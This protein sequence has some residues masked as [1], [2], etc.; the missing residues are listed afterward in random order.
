MRYQF[1]AMA[2]ALFSSL[3][4]FAEVQEVDHNNFDQII[5]SGDTVVEFY[6]SSCPACKKFAPVYDAVSED[7]KSDLRFTKIE[8][9]REREVA[10]RYNIKH[11]PTLILFRDGKEKERHVG[12]LNT[13][14]LKSLID[15]TYN[16]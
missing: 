12:G 4:G 11:T 5:E 6:L 9:P 8:L 2:V 16:Y 7:Y 15:N 10:N 1:F 13:S 14:E 3:Q